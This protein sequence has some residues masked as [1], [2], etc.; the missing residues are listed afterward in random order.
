M[1]RRLAIHVIEFLRQSFGSR[2]PCV[3]YCLRR[4]TGECGV[5]LLALIARLYLKLS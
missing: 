2:G 3:S 1:H 5:D 4:V